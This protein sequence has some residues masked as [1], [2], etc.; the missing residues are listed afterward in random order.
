MRLTIGIVACV[1]FVA[2][3]NKSAG[4]RRPRTRSRGR[5]KVQSLSWPTARAENSQ[6]SIFTFKEGKLTMKSDRGDRTSTYKLDTSKKPATI[7][8]TA[9]GGSRD[10]Q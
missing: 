5:G 9:V 4:N 7:D 2:A 8:L 6:G 10:G 1:L 3:E